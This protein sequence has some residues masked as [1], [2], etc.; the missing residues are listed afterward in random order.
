M[1]DTSPCEIQFSEL[2]QNFTWKS[3]TLECVRTLDQVSHTDVD[4]QYTIA[5]FIWVKLDSI[6]DR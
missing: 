5:P 6:Y 3:V 2:V 4:H 1:C